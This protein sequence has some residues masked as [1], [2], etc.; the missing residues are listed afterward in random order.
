[1]LYSYDENRLLL[2]RDRIE[3]LRAG[4]GGGSRPAAPRERRRHGA[5]DW[6]RR[7]AARR[8]ELR[9]APERP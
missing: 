4:F 1:M 3:G 7:E 5:G 8:A 2:A 9:L 6:Q